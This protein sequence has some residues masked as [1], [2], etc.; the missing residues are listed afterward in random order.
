MPELPEVQTT[1][2]GLNT[3][4]VGLNIAE[5]WTD[6][7]SS[8]HKGKDSI[9]NPEYFKLFKREVAGAK[10]VKV[11]RRAKNV[12]IELERSG[13]A[14]GTILIHMKMTGHVLYGRFAFDPKKKRDPWTPLDEGPLPKTFNGDYFLFVEHPLAGILF[15]RPRLRHTGTS[16]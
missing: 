2:H 10:I 15:K 6:Y 4:V 14:A 16:D 1:A 7:G 13:G 5:V 9:K 12:L 8:F 3:H 11:H